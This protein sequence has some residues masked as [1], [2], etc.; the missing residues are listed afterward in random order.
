MASCKTHSIGDGQ[1]R[2]V[3]T[4]PIRAIGRF[5]KSDPTR[6]SEVDVGSTLRR[7]D[8]ID[9]K[10]SY[11]RKKKKKRREKCEERNTNK[12]EDKQKKEKGCYADVVYLVFCNHFLMLRWNE[13]YNYSRDGRL[14]I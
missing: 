12:S 4:R 9:R 13:G 8:I 3:S 14:K 2:N 11:E 7:R 10:P 1:R 5:G 6:R